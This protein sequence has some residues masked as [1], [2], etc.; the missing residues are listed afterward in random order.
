MSLNSQA[1][2]SKLTSAEG[3]VKR[4]ADGKG[5]T[6]EVVTELYLAALSRF[7]NPD[8]LQTA[9]RLFDAKG[10]TRQTATEDVLWAL[11]NSPE[12]VFNH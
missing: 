9:T 11:L 10:S 2:Q 5:T 4:L 6:D 7:P 1:L 3:R 8:E 12:F